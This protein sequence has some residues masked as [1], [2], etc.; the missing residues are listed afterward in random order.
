[1]SEANE[2]YSDQVPIRYISGPP[3]IAGVRHAQEISFLEMPQAGQNEHEASS[4]ISVGNGSKQPQT[5]HTSKLNLSVVSSARD[6]YA[7][8]EQFNTS[9]TQRA[10]RR[11]LLGMNAEKVMRKKRKKPRV[12]LN[13]HVF[14]TETHYEQA[15]NAE[16]KLVSNL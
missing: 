10:R 9:V 16:K 12:N 13:C 7:D 6:E 4:F 8:L 2:D 15:I 11:L 5:L 3:E 1:M 14:E